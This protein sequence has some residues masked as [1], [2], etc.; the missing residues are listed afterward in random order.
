LRKKKSLRILSIIFEEEEEE[1]P[2]YYLEKEIEE[3][4]VDFGDHTHIIVDP[5]FVETDPADDEEEEL[6]VIMTDEK[7]ELEVDMESLLEEKEDK[8]LRIRYGMA[9]NLEDEA[10]VI[11]P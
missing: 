4:V 1:E 7:E 10:I 11:V 2:E 5:E 9:A 8:M 6:D 3:R